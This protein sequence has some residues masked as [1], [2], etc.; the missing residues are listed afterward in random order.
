MP[1]LTL[2]ALVILLLFPLLTMAD[3]D[4]KRLVVLTTYPEEVFSRFEAAF[5]TQHPDINIDILWQKPLS[6]MPSL[7]QAG[8]DVYW[9]P[10]RQNFVQLSQSG[11]FQKLTLAHS[12]LPDHIGSFLLSDPE[13][14][15]RAT[16]VAGFGIV[17]NPE[18]LQ[19]HQLHTP[20][21]WIDLAQPIYATHIAFP[22]PSKVGFAPAILD[23]ILQAYGWNAGWSLLSEI[24][25]NSYLMDFS[26]GETVID[27]IVTGKNA[28]GL[29][30]DFFAAS[31]IA[32]GAALDFIYPKIT[33]YSPA[34][35][36]ITAKTTAIHEA[37]QFVE[38]LVSDA[39]QKTL[40]DP[41][42]RKLP[43]RPS[44][45]Q[46]APAGYYNP[47][48]AVHAMQNF[49]FDN[50]LGITSRGVNVALFDQLFTQRQEQLK[51]LWQAIRRAENLVQH[52][53]DSYQWH[54]IQQAKHTVVTAP[55]TA[56]DAAN[57]NL[58]RIFM[59]RKSAPE[60]E[61]Q[62]Q[63]IEKQWGVVIDQNYHDALKL[64]LDVI[65]AY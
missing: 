23:L 6:D 4:K 8:V 17:V 2:S 62:A 45:Y 42:I 14:Y 47:F 36:A 1:K 34:Y 21:E 56:V 32:N 60:L 53:Y 15:Y 44:V 27:R 12:E 41:D 10:S 52:Q 24:V 65:A 54:K 64:I 18:Y 25:S 19:Q 9:A 33:A 43:V 31:K 58:Q 26:Q 28:I 63:L 11:A 46:N 61:T 29:S 37:Q 50:Q 49:K 55:L 22:I 48:E 40:F 30:I 35:V 7:Q 5:E 57:P 51:Q 20:K 16:E 13:G 3:A 59:Q 38:F 39:G